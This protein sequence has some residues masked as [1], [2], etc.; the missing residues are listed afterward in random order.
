MKHPPYPSIADALWLAY[1]P[2]VAAG[3]LLLARRAVG[4]VG[5][6]LAL[7][8][9]I[10]ATGAAAISAALLGP[11]MVGYAKAE[12]LEVAV[13]LAYPVGDMLLL[14]GIAAAAVLVGWRRDFIA[15]GLGLL[16]VVVADTVYVQQEATTGYVEGTMLDA[17]WTVSAAL[18]A[19]AAWQRW[20]GRSPRRFRACGR[21]S[22]R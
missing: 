11:S 6:S 4:K 13:N 18:L 17:G 1:Y 20:D 15:L 14:G 8:G 5:R 22:Y 9:A 19:F 3:A 21:S 10:A 12:P 16:V 7:D 2:F